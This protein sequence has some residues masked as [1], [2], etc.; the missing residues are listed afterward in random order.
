[1][2]RLFV[3]LETPPTLSEELTRVQQAVPPGCRLS[4][5]ANWH[6]TLAF[7]GEAD[8]ALVQ[9]VL[10]VGTYKVPQVVLTK[11]GWF[12]SGGRR[13]YWLGAERTPGLCALHQAVQ[14]DLQVAGFEPDD[15]PFVPHI[16]LARGSGTQAEEQQFQRQPVTPGLEFHSHELC[17]Y[18]SNPQPQ[19]SVY[20]V[21]A[22]YRLN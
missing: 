11:P 22:R 2:T 4:L 5:P 15:K 17:L 12:G 20:R 10:A 6:L 19:R 8:L 1:M 13:T 7:I 14:A 16:T 9:A 3:G 21:E 18:S